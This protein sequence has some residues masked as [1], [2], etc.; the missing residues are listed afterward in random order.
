MLETFQPLLDAAAGVDLTDP[1]AARAT[2]TARLDPASDEHLVL[3]AV[4]N[5]LLTW[6]IGLVIAGCCIGF[7]QRPSPA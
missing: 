2:L 7:S 1:E 5:A 4:Q 6:C 3:D